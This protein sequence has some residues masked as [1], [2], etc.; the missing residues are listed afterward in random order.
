MQN[1]KITV[2]KSV[3]K[4]SL[5]NPKEG[6]VLTYTFKIANEGTTTLTA[7]SL[8][9]S[10]TGHGL[11]EITMNYPDD[12]K[13]LLPGQ[14]MSATATY[15]LKDADIKAKKVENLVTAKAKDPGDRE[16]ISDKASVTTTILVT[17]KPTATPTPTGTPS[18]T[19]TPSQPKIQTQTV[20]SPKTGDN[21]VGIW[22]SVGA[23]IVIPG[24]LFVLIKKRK[25][26]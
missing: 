16:I 24:I 5:S 2:K 19:P 11:S 18:P 26:A 7:I 15:A 14:S 10:L 1:S 22:A 25:A 3:D 8:E 13:T 12:T 6:T 20:S 23:L 17:V 4:A 9:D 21:T